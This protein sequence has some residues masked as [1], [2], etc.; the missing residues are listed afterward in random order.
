M[1]HFNQYESKH[2]LEFAY[3]FKGG[4]GG[5]VSQMKK[6]LMAADAQ[7]KELKSLQDK[8]DSRK[9]ALGRKRKGRASLISGTD[10]GLKKN[11]GS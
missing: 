11:L 5:S 6:D 3:A 10:T 8:E 1:K 9:S 4:K 7:A 2:P